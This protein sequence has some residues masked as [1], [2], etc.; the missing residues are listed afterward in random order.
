M[1]HLNSYLFFKSGDNVLRN[2]DIFPLTPLLLRLELTLKCSE[3]P[4]L[5]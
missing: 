3:K 4:K 5:F 1:Q 2:K